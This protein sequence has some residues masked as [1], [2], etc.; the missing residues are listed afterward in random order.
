MVNWLFQLSVPSLNQSRSHCFLSLESTIITLVSHP[1]TL[2]SNHE[3]QSRIA[4]PEIAGMMVARASGV[5][6]SKYM[7]S[8][9]WEPLGIT[10][11]TF[12]L[13]QRSDMKE[14]MPEVSVKAGGEHLLHRMTKG[15]N[16]KLGWGTNYLIDAHEVQQD[17]ES[18]T[19]AFGSAADFHKIL[20]SITTGDGKL[21]GLKMCDELFKPQ[22]STSAQEHR[23]KVYEFRESEGLTSLS[24]TGSQLSFSLGGM[25]TL[26]DIEGRR[27]KGTIERWRYH[28]YTCKDNRIP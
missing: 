17:D 19:G 6:L 26:V 2:I 8:H 3:A 13:E 10:N 22:L 12:H 7:K 23:I 20:H 27:R 11:I 9:M 16:G 18:G 4:G 24:P 25:M 5:P 21:L 15:L 1:V 14:R 28:E